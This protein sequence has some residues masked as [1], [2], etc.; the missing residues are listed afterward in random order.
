MKKILFMHIGKMGR[1]QEIFDEM[2]AAVQ[3]SGLLAQ[4]DHLYLIHYG[5]A[6][7]VLP[8]SG[9]NVLVAQGPLVEPTSELITLSTLKK[10]ANELT[11]EGELAYIGYIHSKGTLTPD[12]AGHSAVSDWRRYMQHFAVY[13]H[14]E[15]FRLLEFYD[16]VGV[17]LKRSPGWHYS[18]NF[19]WARSD[20]VAALPELM[21]AELPGM[22][23]ARHRAEFYIASNA[24]ARHF[25]MWDSGIHVFDRANHAY[26]PERYCYG[27]VMVPCGRSTLS[28]KEV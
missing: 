15:V 3:G 26:P 8:R 27:V 7:L 2:Y 17:D 5:D 20:Y 22:P 24:N 11:A 28:I 16:T 25:S 21:T 14:L 19:W 23:S 9:E 6:P 4:L 12:F 10:M 1:Y 13:R 18:G